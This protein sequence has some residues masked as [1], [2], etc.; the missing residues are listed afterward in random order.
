MLLYGG[1][2]GFYG[3]LSLRISLGKEKTSFCTYIWEEDMCLLTQDSR[4]LTKR[5]IPRVNPNT[6][7]DWNK[8]NQFPQLH[9]HLIG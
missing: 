1:Q 2:F 5:V 6:V 7:T 3:Q 9:I 4:N 8:L